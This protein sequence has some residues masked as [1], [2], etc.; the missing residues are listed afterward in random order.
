MESSHKIKAT[1]PRVLVVYQLYV[2]SGKLTS[3]PVIRC[4]LR[5]LKAQ[6][7]TVRE[8]GLRPRRNFRLLIED[9]LRLR[10]EVKTF[11]PT[12]VHA[13]SGTLTAFC[14]ALVSNAPLIIT[15]RGSDLN[16]APG[17]STLR[18]ILQKLLSYFSALRATELIAVSNELRQKLNW[19]GKVTHVIPSGVDQSL[20]KPI[21]KSFARSRLGWDNNDKVVLFNCGFNPVGKRLGLAEAS[22]RIAK[23]ELPELRMHV[24]YGQTEFE[25]MPL[26]YNAADCLLMTSSHEGSPN[27]VKE[28]LACNTPIVSVDVGD[29]VDRL[30]GATSSRISEPTPRALGQAIVQVISQ[31]QKAP[32][33]CLVDDLSVAVMTKRILRIYNDIFDRCSGKI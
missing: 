32:S 30:N 28:A 10:K 29:V 16:W 14:C 1:V 6:D 26:Y 17:N 21:P 11:Q 13:Q 22:V 8:F 5:E 4:F 9:L 7:I 3:S 19:L 33:Q 24:L 20:F 12:I 25:D 18:N 23:E 2:A 31:R 15:F 27:V